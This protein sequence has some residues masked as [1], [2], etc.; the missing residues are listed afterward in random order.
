MYS[1]G[2]ASEATPE[3]GDLDVEDAWDD[4]DDPLDPSFVHLLENLD[5]TSNQSPDL[6]AVLGVSRSATPNEIRAAYKRL[7]LLLHPDRHSSTSASGDKQKNLSASA[8]TAFERV[9]SAYAVLSD[10][11]KRAVYDAFGHDGL[12]TQGW[13]MM[14][15]EKSAPELRLEYLMLKEKAKSEKLLQLTH[16]TSEFS[17]GIDLTDIFDRYLKEPPEERALMPSPTVYQLYLAQSVTAGLTL[18]NAVS[19]A[20]Q[21]TAHNGLGIGTWMVMWRHY[22]GKHSLLSFTTID[23]EV[24]YGRGGRGLGVGTRVRRNFGDRYAGY[25]GVALTSSSRS[26]GGHISLVPSLSA[27]LTI[28]LLPRTQ[29]R[30]EWRWN[31]DPGLSTELTWTSANDSHAARLSAQLS[32]TGR[33]GIAVRYEKTVSWPWLNPPRGSGVGP[34][35]EKTARQTTPDWARD[36]DDVELNRTKQ[37]RFF[38]SVDVNTLDIAEFSLGANCFISEHSCLSGSISVSLQRG[39]N[40][41]LSLQRGNQ[42]YSLPVILSEECNLVAASYGLVIP[43]LVFAAVRTLAYEPYLSRQLERAQVA[44]RTK[45]K[46]ELSRRRQEAFATQ[47]LMR[48]SALH[49]KESELEIGGLV[50]TRAVYGCLLS[51]ANDLTLSDAGGALNVDVTIPLQCMV[52]QSK[53]RLPPGRWSDLQGFYDPCLGLIKPPQNIQSLRQL[54]VLYT[55]HG[56]THEVTVSESQGLAIPMTKHLIE[57]V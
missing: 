17:L 55:F 14:C 20:G 12:N 39:V 11:N 30:L 15:C 47:S 26:H 31:L 1:P 56:R 9:S 6:Y 44:R 29:A 19:L 24:S 51:S 13:D 32:A 10:P 25:F 23:T 46:S 7:C 53:L 41:R 33:A 22:C 54:R 50:I 16:P 37:G 43:V 3:E 52:E 38:G 49:S 57:P 34:G 27:G 4:T 8:Q 45:L 40:L 21:V 35:E 18:R 42:T 28:Q 48:N 5:D 2:H 36:E